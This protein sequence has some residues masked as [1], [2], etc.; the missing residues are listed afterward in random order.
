[1]KLA[2]C[3]GINDYPGTENDLAGCRNDA[4]DWAAAL[5]T[6]GFAIDSLIDGAATGEAIRA[7]IRHLLT[8]A[9]SGDTV[10]ITYSGH[11]TWVPDTGGDEPDHRDEALCP[12]DIG[13]NGPLLDDDLHD[14]F[15]RS[16]P[17][18]RTVLISDSCHS[19][20]L[21]RL[22]HPLGDHPTRTRFLPPATFLTPQDRRRATT[23]DT[24]LPPRRHT[25]ATPRLHTAVA[26]AGRHR[27]PDRPRPADHRP[28]ALLLAGCADTE[29]AYDATFNG[30][31]N[32]A[33]TYVALSALGGLPR[34]ATYRDW[35]EAIRV[36]LPSQ[37]Y[38]Q[39][40]SLAATH[41]QL[42]WPLLA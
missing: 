4:E 13:E 37:D 12:H 41:L 32:G 1:M 20:T 40:P 19:G 35:I 9:T 15:A 5:S 11:G 28:T 2:L 36:S 8:T 3:I 21:T 22:N 7:G 39:T 26:G 25:A 42:A 30:R 14:L 27:V 18:V 16:S 17:G 6:R 31:P 38:P 23:L 10:V 33:F 24:H 29:Y 34:S